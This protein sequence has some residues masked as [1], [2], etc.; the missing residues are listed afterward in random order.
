MW[1][2]TRAKKPERSPSGDPTRFFRIGFAGPRAAV[3]YRQAV[4]AADAVLHP[5][6]HKCLRKIGTSVATVDWEVI[7]AKRVRRGAA[8]EGESASKLMP[9]LQAML[10]DPSDD[11]SDDAT[12]MLMAVYLAAFG[13]FYLKITRDTQGVPSA[14]YVL[15][16]ARVKEI[17]NQ[18]GI[19]TSFEYAA[20]A[21]RETIPTRAAVAKSES[22]PPYGAKISLPGIDTGTNGGDILSDTPLNSLG[23]PMQVIE[24]LLRRAVDTASGHPNSKYIVTTPKLLTREQEE[25]LDR[26]LSDRETDGKESGRVLL[27]TGEEIKVTKLDNDLSDLHSKVPLDDMERRVCSAF[28]IPPAML[29]LNGADGA[30]FAQNYGESR[31][32]FWEDTIEPIYLVTIERGLTAALC[33][34]G[35]EIRFNRGS[36][37]ALQDAISARLGKLELVSTLSIDEKRELAGLGPAK[38]GTVFHNPKTPAAPATVDPAGSN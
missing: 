7:Q 4:I 30:K 9:K 3:S 37:A 17:S 29:G 16:P 25:N 23:L 2:F 15:S 24:Q 18:A 36:V 1:P 27:L 5:T 8:A 21:G 19:I 32:A 34:P 13:R 31:L 20:G 10:D 38:A 6:V 22:F 14:I 35:V 12:R 26:E 33:N 28:G 11:V